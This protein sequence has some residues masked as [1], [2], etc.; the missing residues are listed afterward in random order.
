MC[1]VRTTLAEL[2]VEERNRGIG[3]REEEDEEKGEE[4]EEALY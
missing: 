1:S 4:E 3:K 2:D